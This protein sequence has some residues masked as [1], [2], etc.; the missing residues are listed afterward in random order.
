MMLDNTAVLKY[1]EN[2]SM[3]CRNKTTIKGEDSNMKISPKKSIAFIF[4]AALL[5]AAALFLTMLWKEGSE[6]GRTEPRESSKIIADITGYYG[7]Y[8]EGARKN[9]DN[10]LK[11]LEEKDPVTGDKWKSIISLWK[12]SNNDLV[13][14]YGVLPD[15]LP[16][17]DALCMVVLGYQLNYDGTMRDELIGRL[18]VAKASAEKYPNA[19]IVCTGGHTAYGSADATEAGNMSEWLIE[20]GVAPERVIIEDNSL[21]TAQNAIFSLRILSEKYPQVTKLAIIS[22]D[23][24]IATGNLLF[25]ARSTLIADK[26]GNERYEVISNAAYSAESGYLSTV[27]QATALKELSADMVSE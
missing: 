18:Q 17:T 14:N 21:T 24:H 15:G 26:A 1:N 20:N 4:I 6:E 9:V 11:E 2:T 5:C 22:S 10:C 8:G 13:L 19:L 23:Y 3:I 27:F 25:G 12:Y 7:S 16:E